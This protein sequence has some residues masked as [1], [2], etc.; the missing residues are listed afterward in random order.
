VSSRAELFR[1]RRAQ[2]FR[3]G[4]R[5]AA[6]AAIVIATLATSVVVVRST[7]A[8]AMRE[9]HPVAA[10][11]LVRGNARVALAGALALLGG[12]ARPGD[13]AVQS[14]VRSALD[15]DTTIPAVLELKALDRQRRGDLAGAARLYGLSNRLSHRS[16]GTRLWLVQSA[17]ERG[18]AERALAEMDLALRTSSAAADMVFP[19]RANGLDEPA[20][21]APVARL[22]DRPS[23]WRTPFLTYAMNN[24]D[25]DG[26][27]NLLIRLKDR[28][29][30]NAA[31]FDLLLVRLV[32]GGEFANARDLARRFG[33]ARGDGALIADERFADD[34]AHYPF[35]WAVTEGEALG[36]RRDIERGVPVLD[37]HANSAEGGQIAA[38]VLMLAP[39]SYRLA[40]RV[41]R[42]ASVDLQPLWVVACAG[43]T[44]PL[45]TLELPARDLGVSARTVSIPANCPAQWLVLIVRPALNTQSGSVARVEIRRAGPA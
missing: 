45:G 31:A 18:E 25:P 37:Y 11:A 1:A 23:D 39:G 10:S 7:L 13:D 38:Q 40:T 12:G 36:A 14:R 3:F 28:R 27:A 42:A 9:T 8:N 43:A 16:L 2:A 21:V 6:R 20:L 19:A 29:G 26:A 33:R 32:D 34:H 35:G 17:V 15:R 22:V 41:G 44:R 24:A 4:S 5:D 30:I